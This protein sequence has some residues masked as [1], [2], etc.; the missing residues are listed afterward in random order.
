MPSPGAERGLTGRCLSLP[1][2]RI[3]LPPAVLL[4]GLFLALLLNGC[5]ARPWGDSLSEGQLP[6]VVK[7]VET[8]RLRDAACPPTLAGDLALFFQSP[9]DSQAIQ[10]F[11]Q[12]SLPDNYRFVVSNPLGQPLFLLAGNQQEFQ[13]INTSR[14]QYLAG[15]LLSF[16]RRHNIPEFLLHGDW[17]NWL[18]ARLDLPTAQIT[19]LYADRQGRGVWL[20]YPTGSGGTEAATLLL[21]DLTEEVLLS[22]IVED[23]EGKELAVISYRK[24]LA[25]ELCRQPQEI[26]IKGLEYGVDLRLRLSAVSFSA[27]EEHYTLPI[28]PG[29]LRQYHP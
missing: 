14:R 4:L 15:S 21:V 6:G 12:F 29:Y 1:P 13:A 24:Q 11:L 23:Q 7:V 28:P 16:G 25:A 20:R 18:T 26:E 22:R 2:C 8:I 10:G 19:D 3:A 9:L 27:D 17:G 5:A